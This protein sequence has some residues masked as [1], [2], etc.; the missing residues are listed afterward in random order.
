MKPAVSAMKSP[1]PMSARRAAGPW[2]TRLAV[3]AGMMALYPSTLERPMTAPSPFARRSRAFGVT[4]ARGASV[5]NAL[6]LLA[7]VAGLA[8]G[9]KLLWARFRGG[10]FHVTPSAVS[11]PQ[12]TV[13]LFTKNHCGKSRAAMKLLDE[14]GVA[15]EERNIDVTPGAR[16]DLRTLES[17]G[18]PVIVIGDR[19][20]VGWNRDAYAYFLEANGFE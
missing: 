8:V 18:V 15:Y 13:V 7:V 11:A 5:V 19:K 17:G 9:G 14:A 20:I 6:I 12:G 3:G 1:V 4:P 10:M 16:E 2:R